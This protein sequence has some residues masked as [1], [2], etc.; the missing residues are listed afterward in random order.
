MSGAALTTARFEVST[1]DDDA[2]RAWERHNAATLME[3]SCQVPGEGPFV[4]RESNLVGPS[5]RLAHVRGSAHRVHRA[6]SM[7]DA[8]PADAVAVYVARRGDVRVQT[9]GA[10]AVVRPGELL[11]CDPDRPLRR[12]FTHGLDEVAIVIPRTAWTAITDS[13]GVTPVVVDT[14]RD[15]RA[16]SLV[17]LA[18]GALSGTPTTTDDLARIVATTAVL[19]GAAPTGV[20]RRVTAHAFIDDNLTDPGLTAGSVAAAAGLS[21]RQLSRLFAEDGTSVPRHILGRR[22][23]RAYAVLTSGSDS[24]SAGDVAVRCGFCSIPYFSTTFRR[25]F[26]VTPGAARRAASTTTTRGVGLPGDDEDRRT[27]CT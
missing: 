5:L 21:E 18:E 13:A 2:V 11:V 7:I 20:E 15:G 17:R 10:D 4:A 3:L 25:R 22:L 26:G 27:G 23:D 9:E 16:R 8:R 24:L 14:R 6:A 12:T 19:A 1:S